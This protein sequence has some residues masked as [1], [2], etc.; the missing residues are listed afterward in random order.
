MSEITLTIVIGAPASGKSSTITELLQL[1]SKFVILDI[2]WIADS[3]SRLA[4][5]SIYTDSTIWEP[6]GE[7]WFDFLHAI[8]KNSKHA[9]FFTPNRPRDIEN[10][11]TANWIDDSRWL[12]LDCDDTVLQARLD[13]RIEWS[14]DRKL[15]A[16]TDAQ[17][18]R[19][20]N[21]ETIDTGEHKPSDVAQK[22]LSFANRHA[23]GS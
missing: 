3:A 9:I 1:Q 18:L 15:E 19:S 11:G 23:S 7:L 2:D 12:L 5:K 13:T 10:Q 20:F 6:Y 14:E 22:V 16:I 4:G 21:I 8:Y 17:E